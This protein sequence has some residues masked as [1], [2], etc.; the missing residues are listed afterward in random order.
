MRERRESGYRRNDM[1]DLML[2]CIKEVE[3]EDGSKSKGKVS[4]EEIVATAIVFLVA[5]YDTTG[6]TLSF[7]AYAMSQ[8]P[9]LQE[10][11]QAGLLRHGVG[12]EGQRHATRPA[13]APPGGGRRGIP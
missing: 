9:G 8:Q 1:I 11:L 6:M 13:G 2:D 12:Q 4:E 10:H 5:G 7:L 3:K